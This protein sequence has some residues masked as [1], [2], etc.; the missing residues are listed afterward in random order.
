[1]HKPLQDLCIKFKWE[2]GFLTYKHTT[3]SLTIA[4]ESDEQT[5][6]V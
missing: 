1:M 5:Y 3:N 4:T 6:P 2:K